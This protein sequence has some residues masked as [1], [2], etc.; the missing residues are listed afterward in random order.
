M[1][2]STTTCCSPFCIPADGSRFSEPIGGVE[3]CSGATYSAALSRL[4]EP[5]EVDGDS[6]SPLR[7][8]VWSHLPSSLGS[9]V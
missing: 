3:R 8:D 2:L 6:I 4:R 9:A 7:L 5:C 1:L